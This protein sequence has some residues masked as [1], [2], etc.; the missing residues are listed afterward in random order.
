MFSS[1][2]LMFTADGLL[3]RDDGRFYLVHRSRYNDWS[4]LKGKLE[5]GETLAET[6]VREVREETRCEVD[7]GRFTGRCEYRVPDDVGT[8]NRPKGVFIWH[9]RVANE[10][11]FEPNAKMDIRQ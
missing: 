9:M 2:T 8:W 1:P 10:H 6:V 5:P 4:F 11:Q 3:C 7:C